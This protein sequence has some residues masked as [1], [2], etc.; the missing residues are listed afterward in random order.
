MKS[1]TNT[2][3]KDCNC[4]NKENFPLDE[5]CLVKCLVCEATVFTTDQANTYFFQLK[6]ILKVG[7][8]TIYYPFAQ[9]DTNTEL[10][11]YIFSLKDI[12]TEFSLKWHVKSKAMSYSLIDAVNGNVTCA[13]LKK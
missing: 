3:K 7:T 1:S 13:L 8:K 6:V 10:S 5:N 11:K 9:K 4:R 12:K 2:N